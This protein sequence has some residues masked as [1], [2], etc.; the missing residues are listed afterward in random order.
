MKQ[1]TIFVHL[2]IIH[3]LYL[4]R[5]NSQLVQVQFNLT[6]MGDFTGHYSVNIVE[7]HL[8]V[9]GVDCYI[10]RVSCLPLENCS[11]IFLQE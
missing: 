4:K 8:A 11:G 2:L 7:E 1:E 5:S 10:M 6:M 3:P 9:K